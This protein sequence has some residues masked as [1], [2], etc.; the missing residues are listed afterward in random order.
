MNG[1]GKQLAGA[2]T[3][4]LCISSGDSQSQVY[5]GS[6]GAYKSPFH[7]PYSS[8]YCYLQIA[9]IHNTLASNSLGSSLQFSLD[10]MAPS[11]PRFGS[12]GR[13]VQYGRN[14]EQSRSCHPTFDLQLYVNDHPAR[15]LHQ[16]PAAGKLGR[17]LP[18]AAVSVR[19][20]PSQP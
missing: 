4:F 3:P 13:G 7:L 16:Y 17:K 12:Q 9:E 1:L 18:S 8:S 11:L 20:A 10:Y 14:C 2:L 6:F 5:G 19:Q 15:T